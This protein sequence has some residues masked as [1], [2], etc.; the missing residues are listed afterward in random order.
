[1]KRHTV[2]Y[3]DLGQRYR[4]E[5]ECNAVQAGRIASLLPAGKLE[6]EPLRWP[7]DPE[8]G[9]LIAVL[10]VRDLLKRVAEATRC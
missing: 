8:Q 1:M 4:V 7:R 2:T 5:L 10:M 6:G 9:A 3:S